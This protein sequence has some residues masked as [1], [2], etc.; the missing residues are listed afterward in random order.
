MFLEINELLTW[1]K[2]C[3]CHIAILPEQEILALQYHDKEKTIIK[4]I[5]EISQKWELSCFDIF[6]DFQVGELLFSEIKTQDYCANDLYKQIN[7]QTSFKTESVLITTS[8]STGKSKLV[9]YCQGAFILSCMSWQQA[10]LFD[11]NL[12]GGRCFTPMFTHTMGIRAFFN[13]LWTGY[14][15]CIIN[16]EWFL[17]KPETVRY[18]LLRMKPEHITGGPSIYNLLLELMRCFP[19]LKNE[20]PQSFKT[21]I[22]SGTSIDKKTLKEIESSFGLKIYNAFGTTETQQIL[23]TLLLQTTGKLERESLGA[24]LPGVKIGLKRLDGDKRLY[25]LYAHSKF[26]MKSD[27]GYD[28]PSSIKPDEYFNT[29]DIVCMNDE[30][31]IFYEGRKDVDFIKDGFGVKIPVSRLYTYYESLFSKTEHIEFFSVKGLPGLAA[32]IFIKDGDLTKGIVTDEKVISK[33][34]G[35]I[36]EINNRLFK[37]LEPFEY[38]H[39]SIIRFMLINANVPNTIKGTVSCF[40]IR[41]QYNEA[42]SNLV[43]TLGNSLGIKNIATD[44]VRETLYTHHHNSYF[45]KMMMALG[46]DYTYHKSEKDSLYTIQHGKELEILDFTGGFGT[47]LLG[48]N[49]KRIN[50]KVIDFLDLKEIPISDQG[51]IQKYTGELAEKLNLIVGNLTHRDYNVIFGSTGSEAVEVAIHHAFLEWKKSFEEIRRNQF[52]RYGFEVGDLVSRI[53]EENAAKLTESEVNILGLKDAFHGHSS[54]ARTVLGNVNKRAKFNNILG[55]TTLFI[56]DT[57]DDWK[58][59]VERAVKTSK[60]KLKRVTWKRN[61]HVVEEFEFPT[62]IGAIAEP[63]TGEGGIRTVNSKV[64]RFLA[65]F[66][67]PL[68]LDEIQ[69]G[70]GRSGSFL[71]SQGINANY[72]LFAKTLGGNVEKISAVLIEKSR[73]IKEF[74]DFYSST[75]ANGGLAAKIALESLAIIEEDNIIEKAQ[76]KGDI[77]ASKLNTIRKKYPDVVSEITGKGLMQGIKFCDYSKSDNVLFRC[78]FNENYLGLVFSA[79]LLLKHRIRILPS[80]SSPNMLRVEPSAYITRDEICQLES[81]LED[82]CTNIE[83]NRMY[84]IFKPLMENDPFP[85]CK[86]KLPENGFMNTGIEKPLPGAKKVGIIAHFV[87]PHAELRTFNKDLC[88]ASDTGLRI[89]FNRFQVLMQAKPF[90]LFSKNILEGKIHFSFI[91]LAVDSAEL[92]RCIRQRKR[93]KINEKIQDAVNLASKLGIKTVSLG[94]YTSII[95]NNGLSLLESGDTRIITGNTL[96]AASGIT[97]LKRE[98]LKHSTKN[99]GNI[100][101]IVGAAGNIGS[102]LT[103]SFLESEINFEKIYLFGRNAIKLQSIINAMPEKTLAG[104]NL[105][106]KTESDLTLLKECNIIIVATNSNDP[107]IF[108]HHI[109]PDTRVLISDLSI[110]RAVSE[111]VYEMKSVIPLNFASYVTLQDEPEFV[112]SSHTPKGTVFC[113]AAEAILSG[114]EPIDCNLKGKISL[115]GVH[116]ITQLAIKH[117]FFNQFTDID[118]G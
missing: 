47:N 59:S 87:Y 26:G 50:K 13:A 56:D 20:L 54:G 75:F 69:C 23:N 84:E 44:Y 100:L 89:L 9:V 93:G 83:N 85:D 103:R 90:L 111:E 43:D 16:T 91:A 6:N 51:S 4:E 77:I 39:R 33:Y 22:S 45:G 92:D 31:L 1:L 29:G 81:A 37:R 63:I 71:A 101:G 96:T 116:K 57:R 62:M 99:K 53:W 64:L 34:S 112:I 49:N 72:Y 118:N 11:I 19:E 38:R 73:Y 80:I 113:C 28:D 35:I 25:E 114:L 58:E 76:R 12:L 107:I 115:E 102:I 74:P 68:I 70:L 108:P 117:Q 7:Q 110:P 61:T 10:G 55:I 67:F 42:I 109:H 60:I 17:E 46:I 65:S 78:V 15:V 86:G 82:L 5:K 27:S 88:K 3:N 8:G 24:P 104:R 106:P 14:P 41:T 66:D 105:Q 94:A 36:A 97:R 21:L 79:Y 98:M 52:E 48:H 32:L 95:S 30:K 18:F 2:K 40:K